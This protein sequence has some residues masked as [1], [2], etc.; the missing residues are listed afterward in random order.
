MAHVLDTIRDEHQSM[1]RILQRLERQIELFEGGSAADYQLMSE[2]IEYFLTFP[3]L[4]HHPKENLILA[5]L[6]ERAPELARKVGDLEAEHATISEELHK[7]ARVLANVLLEVEMPRDSFASMARAFIERE[8]KHISEEE[9][10][11][12]PAALAGLTEE[13]WDDISARTQA[14]RDPLLE[15]A[16]IRFV[17]IR[18]DEDD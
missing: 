13:D 14:T 7:F 1:S 18:D 17:L 4:F 3:D 9:E 12:L 11:F 10:V 6:R 5:K 15:R 2:I 8:R 16:K